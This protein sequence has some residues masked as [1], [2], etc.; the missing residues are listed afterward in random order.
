MATHKG[1]ASCSSSCCD[2]NAK[3]PQKRPD[4]AED[5]KNKKYFIERTIKSGLKSCLRIPDLLDDV[6]S[7]VGSVSK[8]TNQAGLL[9]GYIVREC[10]ESNRP[11]PELNLKFFVSL[12]IVPAAD[13]HPDVQN[14]KTQLFN[15]FPELPRHVGDTNTLTYAA[16]RMMTNFM[17]SISEAF[18]SRLKRRIYVWAGEN[19]DK[20]KRTWTVQNAIMGTGCPNPSD[21]V[22]DELDFIRKEREAI[23]IPEG[24]E[25]SKDWLKT[26]AHS[27]LRTYHRWLSLFAM[28]GL[29]RFPLTPYF[30]IKRHFINIDSRVLRIIMTSKK[31]LKDVKPDS[32]KKVTILG[33]E[34][35]VPWISDDY[36][37]NM[38]F[39]CKNLA[40][41]KWTFSGML[42][43][44]GVSGCFH[45]KRRKT[46]IELAAMASKSAEIT[47]AK[48]AKAERMQ[49]QKD[50]PEEAEAALKA[51]RKATAEAKKEKKKEVASPKEPVKFAPPEI[52]EGDSST[53]P[54]TRPNTL[55]TIFKKNGKI[56]R[57]K[58]TTGQYYT[59]S[60]VRAVT[61][62]AQSLMLQIQAEQTYA[63]EVSHRSPTLYAFTMHITRYL[64]VYDTLWK[65]KLRRVW[66]RGRFRTYIGKPK[67]MDAYFRKLKAEGAGIR[68]AYI[69]G[70]RWSP[71]QKGRESGPVDF[72]SRRFR[73]YHTKMVRCIYVKEDGTSGYFWRTES[74]AVTVDEHLTSQCCWKCGCRTLPVFERVELDEEKR[75]ENRRDRKDWKN[76]KMVR[77]LRFCDSKTCGCLIDRDFQGAMNIMACGMAEEG[78]YARPHQLTRESRAMKRTDKFFL[79]HASARQAR[80]KATPDDLAYSTEKMFDNSRN[81]F[82]ACPILI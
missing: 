63:D 51:K 74:N 10:I 36:I 3:V 54:G 17:N 76:D 8:A 29:K 72:A 49:F 62:K 18:S 33:I 20:L 60:G 48:T 57:V 79:P 15:Q 80:H 31:L 70:G 75:W 56:Q 38:A 26:N 34:K 77:G 71:S 43:L 66:A 42:D 19:A 9:I 23:G 68:N 22:G 47:T 14:A 82:D 65:Q 4:K 73:R 46:S 69:G 50:F 35:T 37:W 53:D 59:D 13:Y 24:E 39:D 45:F 7:R 6:D 21:A 58:L 5:K 40:S 64:Q 2:E 28:L 12:F 61:K 67:A 81:Q 32:T 27:V 52:Q 55:Y 25:I 11:L 78:G 30:G 44:D 16:G 1:V 41:N